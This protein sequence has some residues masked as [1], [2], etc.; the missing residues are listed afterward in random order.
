MLPRITI[1]SVLLIITGCV[2]VRDYDAEKLEYEQANKIKNAQSKVDPFNNPATP[3]YVKIADNDDVYVEA[4]KLKPFKG[5]QNI[6]LDHW[7]INATNR[8]NKTVCVAIKWKL[9]DFEF[10]SELPLEFLMKGKEFLKVGDMRQSIWSFSDVMIAIPPSGYVDS[11]N[12]RDAKIETKTGKYTCDM[13]EE[14][15][16]EPKG[17]ND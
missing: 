2:T 3:D 13:L 4:I 17:D 14:D 16:Q 11:M 6:K 9:Q 5:P 10:T 7:I 8:S 15:I 1:L 12:V